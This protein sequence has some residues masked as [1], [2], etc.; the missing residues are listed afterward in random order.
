MAYTY[1]KFKYKGELFVSLSSEYR[2]LRDMYFAYRHYGDEYK[3]YDPAA[4]RAMMLAMDEAFRTLFHVDM[5][6]GE[7]TP[8][9]GYEDRDYRAL[10]DRLRTLAEGMVPRHDPESDKIPLWRGDNM[11]WHELSREEWAQVSHDGPGF[12][13]HLIPFLHGDGIPRPTVLI[14]GGSYRI[15][16]TEG[17]P[18][19]EFYYAQG[20]NAFVLNTRHGRGARVRRS[21]N[22][23]MDLQRAV[24]LLRANAEEYGVDPDRIFYN[25][26]SMGCRVA[27]DLIDRLGVDACPRDLDASYVP[28]Q[29]DSLSARLN[30]FVAVY[31]ACFPQDRGNY[32]DYPPVFFVIGNRDFSLWRVMPYISDLA[33]HGVRVEAHLYD[34]GVHGFALGDESFRLNG[35]GESVESIKGW[36]QLALKWLDRVLK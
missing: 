5:E 34:G 35:D 6:S 22:R 33:V 2:N 18:F 20:Y 21:R 26:S 12:Y 7:V 4:H 11:P 1:L 9:Q 32:G 28:D 17:F 13:P 27:T 24:R 29:T 15:H 25:G 16:V 3:A 23:A 30:A 14:G 36:P 10:E 31:P 8:A 19:A